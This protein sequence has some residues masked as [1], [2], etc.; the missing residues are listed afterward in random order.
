MKIDYQDY[1]EEVYSRKDRRKKDRRTSGLFT[2]DSDSSW[3][4]ESAGWY[5][6]ATASSDHESGDYSGLDDGSWGS[7]YLSSLSWD[8]S[9][10]ALNWA[11]NDPE[12]SEADSNAEKSRASS[13]KNQDANERVDEPSF[14]SIVDDGIWGS[15]FSDI[16][17][18]DQSN[19]GD[20]HFDMGWAQDPEAGAHSSF[21][22]KQRSTMKGGKQRESNKY[23]DR[24]T[25]K[26][27]NQKAFSDEETDLA[28][29]DDDD[30]PS[31]ES[32]D[33]DEISNDT[34]GSAE[35]IMQSE[36]NKSLNFVDND[37]ARSDIAEGV[38][39]EVVAGPFKDFEGI[40]M[41]LEEGS[42]KIQAE[43]DVFGKQT[44]VKVN[45]EDIKIKN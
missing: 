22:T 11:D 41:K 20:A 10:T 13:P 7:E 40:V 5:S 37:L 31:K 16:D 39:I 29:W 18:S 8:D 35:N 25:R 23:E 43:I 42:D 26:S 28:W 32:F 21:P 30:K 1:E 45:K 33:E 17:I 15:S 34:S 27:F 44:T 4:T 12:S 19:Y 2:S 38:V 24:S 6:G 36:W 3:D 14:K 9:S